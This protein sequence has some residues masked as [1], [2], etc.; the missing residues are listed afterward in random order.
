MFTYYVELA[1]RSFRR[2]VALTV[3]MV[4]AIAVGVGASM[5]TLTVLRVL[6]ADPIPGKSDRVFHVQLDPG[7]IDSY[8]EGK[9]PQEQ[10]TRAD[11]ETLLR[12]G[13]AKRQAMMTSG[14]APIEPERDDLDPFFTDGR[15][16]SADFFPMFGVPFVGPSGVLGCPKEKAS[17]PT[18][19]T[20]FSA[21]RS[22]PA[23]P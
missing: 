19:A 16:T 11:A 3:L 21:S 18:R 20:A 5:T 6:S 8:K 17:A 15:W 4:L 14:A 2:N 12:A 9:E 23:A 7:P 22:V 13:R 10:L 1:I